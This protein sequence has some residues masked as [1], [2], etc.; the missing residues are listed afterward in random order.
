MPMRALITGIAGFAGSHLA[1]LLLDRRYEVSGID[2]P[3]ASL[4]NLTSCLDKV[5]LY[6]VDLNNFPL[7]TEAVSDCQPDFL[8]H[9]AAITSVQD[10]WENRELTLRTNIIGTMNLMEACRH[11]AH[12]PRILLVSSS[13]VYGAVEEEKQPITEETPLQ[14]RSPYAVSKAALELLGLQYLHSEN[15]PVYLVRPFNHTGPRQ[16]DSFVCSS[17]A[18]QISEVDRGLREPVLRVGDLS[19][20]RDFS[21]VRDIVR[22][23]LMVV[24]KGKVGRVYNLCSGKA[25][26]IQS[27]VKILLSLS[28]AKIKVLQDPSRLRV[29]E[30]PLCYG[31]HS[32]VRREV[33]WEPTIPLTRTLEDTLNYWRD[34]AANS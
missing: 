16:S 14:P 22:G 7:L 19:V 10:S 27:V 29:A 11:L 26:S 32:R 15:Y 23:Y 5:K 20:R 24:E 31:D 17:F 12:L 34:R 6:Q 1:E 21:D 2:Y 3:G 30:T 33:G 25:Y 4:R 9:L 18:Q 8:F 28:S 13:Q